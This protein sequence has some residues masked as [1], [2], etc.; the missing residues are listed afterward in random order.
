MIRRIARRRCCGRCAVRR[1]ARRA[2]TEAHAFPA[3][4]RPAAAPS[5]DA[6][7][8]GVRAAGGR[9]CRSC[10]R[11]IWNIASICWARAGSRSRMASAMPGSG[12]TAMAPARLCRPTGAMLSMRL[13]GSSR[14]DVRALLAMLSP[15]YAPL[16]WQVDFKSGWRWD[17]TALGVTS[18][19]GHK[20][21]VDIKVPW[22]LARLQHL[23]ALAGG[24][25]LGGQPGFMEAPQGNLR[26]RIPRPGA[27]FHRLQSR[28][29]GRKLGLR[30]GCGDPRRQYG[31]GLGRVS[32]PGRGVRSGIRGGA[33]V[34][35]AGAWPLR[36]RQP[37][38]VWWRARK[39]LSR[40]Y[41]RAG[42]HRRLSARNG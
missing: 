17:E 2:A 31:A 37:G 6:V 38:M 12:R 25:A 3:G 26:P 4:D 8:R 30:H 16:D 40:R 41:R 1:R 33:G 34:F 29:A 35:A 10:C 42:L 24:F 21:G 18:P 7:A 39:S 15:D 23:P 19:I 11:S 36:A 9:R 22:E 20:P 14:P 5:G 28:R 27:G 13:P 32:L